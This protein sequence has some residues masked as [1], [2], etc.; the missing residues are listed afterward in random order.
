MGR[1]ASPY[2]RRQWL[3]DRSLQLRFV[4]PMLAIV[5]FMGATAICGAYGALWYTLYSFELLNESHFTALFNTVL[6][7]IVLELLVIIPIVGWLGILLTH[8]VAGPVGRLRAALADLAKGRVDVHVTLRKGDALT[9]LAEDI[10]RLAA[11]LRSRPP[12]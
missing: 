4:W 5:F 7:T 12:S 8:R 3:V 2:R 6:W 11:F 9:G 1:H 10:N